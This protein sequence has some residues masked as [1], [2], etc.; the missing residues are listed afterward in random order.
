MV[1]I[2]DDMKM[3]CCGICFIISIVALILSIIAIT[4]TN[5]DNFADMNRA[6]EPGLQIKGEPCHKIE[7]YGFSCRPGGDIFRCGENLTC[8]DNNVCVKGTPQRCT[9]R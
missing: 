8:G 1:E 9:T 5:K 3:I 7:E 2:S 6:G 4:N